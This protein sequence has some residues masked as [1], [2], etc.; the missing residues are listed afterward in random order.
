MPPRKRQMKK[1][2]PRR[3]QR[4][5]KVPRSLAMKHY[6]F[7]FKLPSQILVSSNTAG[8][9]DFSQIGPGS[10]GVTQPSAGL[11]PMTTANRAIYPSANGITGFYDVALATSFKLSDIY[12]YG[13]YTALFDAYKITSVSC[14]IEYLNN[15]SG[16]N[17]TGLMPSLYWYWDQDDATVPISAFNIQ[18]KQGVKRRRFTDKGVSTLG[19]PKMAGQLVT[20]AGGGTAGAAILKANWLDCVHNDV[21]HY[22][23]KMFITDL[24]LPGS[25]GVNN[26]FRL[27]WTYNVSFRSPIAAA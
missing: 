23:L 14:N 9:I 26:A 20:A 2:V 18:A 6:N 3:R 21:T 5:S 15:I 25:T 24:Y 17:T 4:K 16:V 1:R 7:T 8:A 19:H 27:N 22:A 10:P 11:L 13:T 12:N